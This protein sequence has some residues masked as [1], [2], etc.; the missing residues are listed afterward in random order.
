MIWIF[1]W[2]LPTLKYYDSQGLN[3]RLTLIG[4]AIK[5]FLKKLFGHE[6]FSSTVPLGYKIYFEKFV[7]PSGSSSTY[8]M[9]IPLARDCYIR[10]W[11]T[12]VKFEAF[13]DTSYLKFIFLWCFWRFFVHKGSSCNIGYDNRYA[14]HSNN[15]EKA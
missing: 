13:S 8:F 1:L 10:I 12:N 5:C 9:Y 4:G 14:F 3:V 2:I 7:K 15:Q 6:I 11:F